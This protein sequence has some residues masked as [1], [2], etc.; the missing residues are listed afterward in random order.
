MCS[1]HL[2]AGHEAPLVVNDGVDAAIAD[3]LCNNALWIE[4]EEES[5]GI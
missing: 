4:E 3:C 5:Q 2:L 1:P